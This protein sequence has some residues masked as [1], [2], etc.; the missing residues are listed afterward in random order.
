MLCSACKLCQ[1]LVLDVIQHGNQSKTKIALLSHL[2]LRPLSMRSKITRA[3]LQSSSRRQRQKSS[4][5]IVFTKVKPSHSLHSPLVIASCLVLSLQLRY[6]WLF[7]GAQQVTIRYYSDFEFIGI[8]ERSQLSTNARLQEERL[9]S[10]E[11]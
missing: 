11:V 10:K 2:Q 1:L 7:N 8:S 9:G 3:C 5:A 6:W 4:P